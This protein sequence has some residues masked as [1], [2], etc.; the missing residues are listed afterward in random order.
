MYILGLHN[1][2]DA[3]VCLL[4]DGEILDAVSE[5]RFRRIKLF[6]G[7]PERSLEYVLDRHG[8]GIG[9]ID[10]FV[11]GWHGRQNDERE[12]SDR[13]SRR[14]S[15]ALERNPD[16]GDILD[17]RLCVERKRDGET[18]QLFE[19]WMKN[20]GVAPERVS[21]V[22]HHHSHAWSAFSCSPF[23][24]ALVFTLDG[25]GDLKSGSVSYASVEDG[26]KECAYNLSFDSLGF[27]YGQITHYLG[28]KPHRH[29]G[30]ISGL[31]AHGDPQKTLPL[32]KTLIDWDGDTIIANIGRFR[33]FYTNIH[34]DVV[35]ALNKHSRED[36]AAGVQRHTEDVVVQ[37]VTHWRRKIDRSGNRHI[38]LAGGVFA[39]VRVNQRIAEI[40]GVDN[41][42]VVPHMGDGG[43]PLGA[44]A[45]LQFTLTGQSKLDMDTV[46]LGPAYSNQDIADCL[47]GYL[48]QVNFDPLRDRVAQTVAD[49]EAEKVVG[50]FDNRMEFGPRALGARSILY[51]SRDHAAND[52]L[53]ARL[54]RTEFMPF[55]PVTPAKHAAKCYEGWRD[56]HI[57]AQFMTRTYNCTEA[58]AEKHP[59]VVHVD[60][61][62]RPQVV[63]P[64]LHGDYYAIVDRY[65]ER[66][67]ER[68]LINTSFNRHEEP[69][70]C[71]P[72]DAIESLLNDTVDIL[73][74]GDYRVTRR[75]HKSA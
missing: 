1:D 47:N 18:R 60:G 49:L 15:Q 70:L 27:L 74:L 43:L 10:H 35:A 20:L 73:I 9:D 11:Y 64:E 67:G 3:G 38:C 61:T 28:Y 71:S 42:Y 26:V 2:E 7:L 52:W 46:Y 13:L 37:Y 31:A 59:A 62:A 50:Y 23:D 16:C 24:E 39:N 68:A 25:R 72:R 34:P 36:I 53:N 69:I 55:A 44:A 6:Q 65:C 29:E 66:T 19:D 21:Y 33:P 32:F 63:R 30:K 48:N 41:I 45:A 56:D 8:I 75:K 58:F 14:M 12:Y 40:D 54:H 4:R 22:D 57:S 51:H 5:E 17:E